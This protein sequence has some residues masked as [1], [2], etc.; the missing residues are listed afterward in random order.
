MIYGIF[1]SLKGYQR[2]QGDGI[3]HVKRLRH[4]DGYGYVMVLSFSLLSHPFMGVSCGS[5]SFT[6]SFQNAYKS[7]SRDLLIY[8]TFLYDT[9]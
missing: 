9:P 4:L 1:P 8:I 2:E 7:S 3:Y 6:N 5:I